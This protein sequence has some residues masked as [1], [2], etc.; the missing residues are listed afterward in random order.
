MG[1]RGGRQNYYQTQPFRLQE[2]PPVTVE[3]KTGLW[4]LEEKTPV[5]SRMVALEKGVPARRCRRGGGERD[6]IGGG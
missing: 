2:N 5:E 3:R 6:L 4:G 1:T